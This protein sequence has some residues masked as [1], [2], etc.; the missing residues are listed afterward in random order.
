MNRFRVH[1][2]RADG[3]RDSFGVA[4]KTPPEAK[5]YVLRKFPGAL[6]GKIKRWKSDKQEKPA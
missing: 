2:T 4:A 6:V 5:D 1:F 3:E